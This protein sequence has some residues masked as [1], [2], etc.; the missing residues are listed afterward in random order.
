MIPTRISLG[1]L[2]A[3]ALVAAC[4]GSTSS[5]GSKGTGADASVD[6]SGATGDGATP[7]IMAT[8]GALSGAGGGDGGTCPTG[9]VCCTTVTYPPSSSCVEQGQCAKGIANECMSAADCSGGQ[10]CCLGSADAGAAGFADAAIPEAGAGNPFANFDPSM[11]STTCQSS[12]AATQ[13]QYCSTDTD[14]P[15][16]LLCQ[17][18]LGNAFAG[19]G[20]SVP[21]VCAPPRPDAG[22]RP[23]RDAGA[24]D[25]ETADAGSDQ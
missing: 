3:L 12:C 8:C 19:F 14:C 21:S 25:A 11:L 24:A 9:Q 20:F 23:V 22:P 18:P 16:G 13:A 10:V 5:G 1:T 15:A 4:G 7:L 17:N 6:D 2:V